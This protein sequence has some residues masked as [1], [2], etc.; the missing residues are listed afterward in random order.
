[1]LEVQLPGDRWEG[2]RG[3]PNLRGPEQAAPLALLERV[4]ELEAH[5][6]SE[7]PAGD[8]APLAVPS[9]SLPRLI[10]A[11][12]RSHANQF[13]HIHSYPTARR[14]KPRDLLQLDPVV[15]GSGRHAS[16]RR[17]S[18]DRDQVGEGHPSNPIGFVDLYFI[19]DPGPYLSVSRPSQ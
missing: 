12:N 11:F 13:V 6:D 2:D 3:P 16:Q 1:M 5:P 9:P 10:D 18:L 4:L 19:H 8:G 15:D 7:E 14:H 17:T